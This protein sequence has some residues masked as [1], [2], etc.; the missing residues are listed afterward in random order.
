MNVKSDVRGKY[1]KS[2]FTR[3]PV[4]FILFFKYL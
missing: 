4:Y 1:L 2:A 3:S